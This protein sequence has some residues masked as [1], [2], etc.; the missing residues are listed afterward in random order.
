M[1]S[2]LDAADLPTGPTEL[3]KSVTVYRF[4]A[5]APPARFRSK[6]VSA[7][8]VWQG[9]GRAEVEGRGYDCAAGSY[10]VK[11]WAANGFETEILQASTTAPFLAVL[12][13]F[14]RDEVAA[15]VDEMQRVFPAGNLY[16]RTDEP[17]VHVQTIPPELRQLVSSIGTL[18][19]STSL[20][21]R[22]LFDLRRR[23]LLYRLL[24][25]LF[26]SALAPPPAKSLRH[27]TD[28][29]AAIDLLSTDL[30]SPLRV[31]D[32]ARAVNMSPSR[33]AHVFKE[34]TGVSPHRFRKQ[35]RLE[36]AKYL[37]DESNWSV[38]SVAAEVGYSN[39]SHFI[40]EF[41]RIFGHTPGSTGGK[42]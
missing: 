33:F 26:E 9:A 30:A 11:A 19:T 28:L 36:R 13:E 24:L 22:L 29:Q 38:T 6:G 35:L 34:A 32:L 41:K 37:L 40:S 21:N 1:P 3:C 16:P 31:A 42:P 25:P 2:V 23:E 27:A 17:C 12:I 10:I 15:A 4:D 20:E 39:V 7:C 8:F 18:A 5:P 14:N